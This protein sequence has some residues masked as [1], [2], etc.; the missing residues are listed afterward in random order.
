MLEETVKPSRASFDVTPGIE[1]G[2]FCLWGGSDSDDVLGW[3]KRKGYMFQNCFCIWYE[4]LI[5]QINYI[6]YTALGV[7]RYFCYTILTNN[8]CVRLKRDETKDITD[9]EAFLYFNAPVV[10]CE[11]ISIPRTG[12]GTTCTGCRWRLSK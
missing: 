11:L 3:Q 5:S 4:R 8:Y 7:L 10:S 9:S 12:L 2:A 1:P 6:I